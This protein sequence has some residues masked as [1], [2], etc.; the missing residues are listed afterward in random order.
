MILGGGAANLLPKS[1]PGSRRADDQDF[2]AKYRAAGYPVATTVGEMQAAAANT[3]TTKML[4]LFH[5]SNM[6][7]VLDR[8]FL[9]A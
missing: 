2:I 7:G 8:K 6:D 4:G 3:A 5:L 9:K 1:A